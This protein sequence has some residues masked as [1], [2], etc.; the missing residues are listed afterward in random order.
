MHVFTERHDASSVP[1]S[2]APPL[3]FEGIGSEVRC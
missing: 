3:G 2:L 1:L